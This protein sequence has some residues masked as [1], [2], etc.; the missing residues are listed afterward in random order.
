MG[1][2]GRREAEDRAM[3]MKQ[4]RAVEG[5]DVRIDGGRELGSCASNTLRWGR[6]PASS[7]SPQA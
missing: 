1:V 4:G 6:Y 7:S 3:G 5:E 2:L